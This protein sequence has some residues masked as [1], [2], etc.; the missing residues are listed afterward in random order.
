MRV[1]ISQM[2]ATTKEVAQACNAARPW[3]PQPYGACGVQG[4]EGGGGGGGAAHLL[5]SQLRSLQ[6]LN[7]SGAL[8]VM[9][10]Q[11][12]LR[13]GSREAELPKIRDALRPSISTTPDLRLHEQLPRNTP[14]TAFCLRSPICLCTRSSD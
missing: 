13:L 12:A 2:T 4:G 1:V 5:P 10:L 9:Q 8:A 3:C 6:G 7:S 11:Q 14:D